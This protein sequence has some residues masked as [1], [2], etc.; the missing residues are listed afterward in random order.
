MFSVSENTSVEAGEHA[1]GTGLVRA[2]ERHRSR[3]IAAFG[4]ILTFFVVQA[5]A[6]VWTNSLALL[7]DAP[8]RERFSAAAREAALSWDQSVTLP[9]ITTVLEALRWSSSPKGR[10]CS[11]TR[12]GH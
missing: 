12:Q 4:V 8:M 5:I 6:A 1:H 11:L 7:A 9:Q 2:C 3:L 10:S